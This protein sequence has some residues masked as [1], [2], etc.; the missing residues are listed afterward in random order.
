M[1][2]RTSQV[3]DDLASQ[4]MS[5]YKV[6][7]HDT[8]NISGMSTTMIDR[9]ELKLVK[10]IV[11]HDRDKSFR[12]NEIFLYEIVFITSHTKKSR[13]HPQTFESGKP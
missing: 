11:Y 4:K 12:I 13:R 9:L 10:V 3:E 7:A 5:W 8:R 6:L 2:I 1:L